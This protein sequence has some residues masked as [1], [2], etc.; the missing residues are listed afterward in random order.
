MPEMRRLPPA[1]A[2]A[3][4][5]AWALEDPARSPWPLPV[6]H[7]SH[8]TGEGWGRTFLARCGINPDD[9]SNVR[10][11][12][13]SCREAHARWLATGQGEIDAESYG[14]LVDAIR[15]LYGWQQFP[16]DWPAPTLVYMPQPLRNHLTRTSGT[17]APSVPN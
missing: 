4:L 9:E 16:L 13:E 7:D 5:A 6:G 3:A 15:D 2:G 1:A 17:A 12:Y 11:S 8:M 10:A 14:M